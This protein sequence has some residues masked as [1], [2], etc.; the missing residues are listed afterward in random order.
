MIIKLKKTVI[1]KHITTSL[2]VAIILMHLMLI[3]C[4][5]INCP[6]GCNTIPSRKRAHGWCTL[7][8]AKTG[9]WGGIRVAFRR[10]RAPRIVTHTL[11]AIRMVVAATIDF[12]LIQTRAASYPADPSPCI[13]DGSHIK[14]AWCIMMRQKWI[15]NE[16]NPQ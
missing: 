3:N 11:F 10:E 4:V 14:L 16:M 15:N 1:R 8:W 9:G 5:F 13:I 7:H 12:S 6:T 2:R